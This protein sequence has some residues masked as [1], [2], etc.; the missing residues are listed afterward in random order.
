MKSYVFKV[1]I[2][3]DQFED[4]RPGFSGHCPSLEG[5]YTWGNTRKE[6]LERIGE[7]V[8]LILDEMRYE[9]KPIPPNAAILEVE[10]PAVLMHM[11]E[12]DQRHS[13]FNRL[14]DCSCVRRWS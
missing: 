2:E 3:D 7:A 8:K 4:G 1:V 6:A 12:I 14:T 9:G 13:N 10:S 5:A 11:T